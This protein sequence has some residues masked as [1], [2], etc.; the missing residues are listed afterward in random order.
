MNKRHL[1][2]SKTQ[3]NTIMTDIEDIKVPTRSSQNPHAD[4][5]KEQMDLFFDAF[6]ARI[7]NAQRNGTFTK[8]KIPT[9][10]KETFKD[11][12]KKGIKFY[13]SHVFSNSEIREMYIDRGLR[14]SNKA[15][16][17]AIKINPVRSNS[18]IL[19]VSLMLDGREMTSC[20]YNCHYCPNEPGQAR[21]Y[22][23]NESVPLLGASENN[24]M[25][26]QTVRRLII[27]ASQGH[28]I[29]KMEILLL[30]GT[31]HSFPIDYRY[32]VVQEIYYACNV[33]EQFFGYNG[34]YYS[35][36][37]EKFIKTSQNTKLS[38]LVSCDDLLKQ[39]PMK[40]L[41]LEKTIQEHA[42]S[43]RCISLVLETRPDELNSYDAINEMRV[44]GCTRVQIGVQTMNNNVLKTINRGHTRE[45]TI[46]AL[47]RLLN[48]GFKIDIHIMPDLPG[49]T[50][51]I[52][53][54]TI[55]EIFSTTEFTFDQIKL[56]PCMDLP[57]T[58]I[59]KWHENYKRLLAKGDTQ[60]IERITLAMQNGES[61]P[62]EQKIWA[63][64]SEY[65]FPELLRTLAFALDCTPTYV[66]INR[67]LRD[68]QK[69]S[70]K[71]ERLGY[72]SDNLCSNLR[73]LVEKMQS[74][75]DIRAREV[76]SNCPDNFMHTMKIY[77]K[78]FRAGNGVEYFISM[79]CE[80]EK[81][82]SPND[83]ILLGLVRLRILDNDAFS[84]F[85]DTKNYKVAII[86]EVHV[87]GI[88]KSQSNAVNNGEV[89][90][91]GIGKKMIAEAERIAAENN[92]NQMFVISG[93]GVMKYYKNLGYSM[94]YPGEYLM[95]EITPAKITSQPD[96]CRIL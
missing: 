20:K 64:Q 19:S 23:S 94:F 48:A 38:D 60:T 80:R 51:D 61:V 87:Y 16:E 6:Y 57:F 35:L 63:P 82:K 69:A 22:L 79:E 44:L 4:L 92:V 59:R 65:N 40:P 17:E 76:S 43:A 9:I 26:M 54:T 52:D 68:F 24:N 30:G 10:V 1:Y 90:H 58:E 25:I 31:W 13:N 46:T 45:T 8:G 32:R 42:C 39:R 29:D 34:I 41:D 72:E 95:K 77:T 75:Y 27:L 53:R 28:P 47:V 12:S 33:Y 91:F 2:N 84:D 15:F 88:M 49:S 81:Q 93:I 85:F 56:Y 86:R 14:G 70:T 7:Q 5:L 66:R 37:L 67:V 11:F 3:N 78:Q 55:A 96:K 62:N 21:S 36:I 73:E 50:P 18:G 83:T 74:C 71:N 89:Q